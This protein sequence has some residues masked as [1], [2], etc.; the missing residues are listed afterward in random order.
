MRS[1]QA[2]TICHSSLLNGLEVEN[3]AACGPSTTESVVT[4]V[5]AGMS[6]SPG[7]PLITPMEP[8]TVPGWA[9]IASAAIEMKYPPDAA[10]SLIDTT[11]GWPALRAL[12][13]SR[14]IASD[15]TY[16]PPGLFTRST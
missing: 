5:L 12:T 9:T 4:P 16:E 15:A 11:T 6:L 1:S 7:L 3:M 10:T 13:T 8:V 2:S 14:Q